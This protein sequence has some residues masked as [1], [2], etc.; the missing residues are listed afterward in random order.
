L[1][2]DQADYE[3]EKTFLEHSIK[4]G[5]EQIKILSEQNV[6]EE[7]G[8]QADVEE[9]QKMNELFS[10]GTLTSPRVTDARRAVLLSS[11]RKLQ[12]A[13]Q[14]MQV[15]KQ[16]DEIARQRERLDDQRKIKLLQELQDAGT[17][18]GQVRAKLQSTGEKLLYTSARSQ[19]VAKA[20]SSRSLRSSERAKRP[21]THR[22]GTGLRA[23]AGRCRRSCSAVE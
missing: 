2:T 21:G 12:T 16:Q 15:Q 1:R 4:Q 8:V 17:R 23:A 10:R 13:A 7:K 14:L 3:R 22:R 18:L 9:L 11:T 20:N 5:E 19:V 6:K